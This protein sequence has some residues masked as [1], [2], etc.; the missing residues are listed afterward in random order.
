MHYHSK[1]RFRWNEISRYQNNV[2]TNWRIDDIY[3]GDSCQHLCN[4][5]GDCKHTGICDCDI[6]YKGDLLPNI[7][8]ITFT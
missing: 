2:I 8:I 6:G 3:I 5:R 1:T 4:G 7:I